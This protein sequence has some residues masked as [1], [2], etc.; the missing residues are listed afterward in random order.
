L[1][2]SAIVKLSPG[3]MKMMHVI[4]ATMQVN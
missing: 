2:G 4:Q 3:M 1:K